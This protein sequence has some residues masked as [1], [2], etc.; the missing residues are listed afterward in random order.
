[1]AIIQGIITVRLGKESELNTSKLLPGEFGFTTDTHR[2]YMGSNSGGKEIMFKDS[3]DIPEYLI[4]AEISA[5]LE[6]NPIENDWNNLRNRPF[7]A[8]VIDTGLAADTTVYMY[9]SIVDGIKESSTV[10]GKEIDGTWLSLG[11]S[12]HIFLDGVEY[13]LTVEE[14]TNYG[15]TYRYV[16]NPHLAGERP[17]NVSGF[18]FAIYTEIENGNIDY[19]KVFMNTTL[20]EDT[21]TLVI[22]EQVLEY[23]KIPLEYLPDNIGGAEVTKESVV[24]ALGY[25]P[26]DKNN[27]PKKLSELTNDSQFI[28]KTVSDLINYYTKN[29]ID[30][31]GYLTQHQD[32][33]G[34]AKKATTLAGYGITDGATKTELENV[35]NQVVSLGGE[36]NYI[37]AEREEVAEKIYEKMTLGN[38]AL[39]AFNTD[40]HISYLNDFSG[41][42]DTLYGLRAATEL[43]KM[44]PFNL[45]VLGGDAVSAT[46]LEGILR[47][48]LIVT[49]QTNGAR[50]PVVHLAGNHD[51]NQ[52]NMAIN[53]SMMYKSHTAFS[54][55]NYP[56]FVSQGTSATNGYIDDESVSI[57]YIFV[58][59]AI[60]VNDDNTV[61]EYSLSDIREWLTKAL[62]GVPENYKAIVFSHHPLN[63]DLPQN[64]SGTA[65]NNPIECQDILEANYQKI[66]ACI[67]GHT[68]N[69]LTEDLH[70]IRYIT[71]PCAGRGARDGVSR[72]TGTANATAFDVFVVDKNSAKIYAIRYGAG[73][74]REIPFSKTIPGEDTPK[75]TNQIPLS[76]DAS[77]ALYNNGQGWKA[78]TRLNSS[79]AEASYTGVEV[80]GFIPAKSGDTIRFANIT[81]D[82]TSSSTYKQQQYLTWYDSDKNKLD[83]SLLNGYET[84]FCSSDGYAGEADENNNPKRLYLGTWF[85]NFCTAKGFDVADVAY[86]RIS[87]EEIDNTSIITVNE[88]IV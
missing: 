7:Y 57:R 26:A 16:G 30:K 45:F 34:Y 4:S 2:L 71:T 35:Q 52:N 65:W 81:C 88:E 75:Y 27:I 67:N 3:V 39:I 61:Y 60:R 23:H 21:H 72:P 37:K 73:E 79:G 47:E 86:F 11:K 40:Q 49:E 80:I 58:D 76:T 14:T 84:Y 63:T 74:D 9:S 48:V 1:M 56:Q 25:T 15:V 42:L 10:V 17:E 19:T 24:G 54:V 66:I 69:Q 13:E 53:N 12:L 31:K 85:T 32:L 43:T 5:Y 68:H 50:C 55:I 22:Y 59:S 6:K 87:A 28:T 8:T 20:P 77:G 36:V 83:S 41:H 38:I 46:D 51:A 64:D 82:V 18:N 44:F 62:N 29:D 33:S 70:G 78:N